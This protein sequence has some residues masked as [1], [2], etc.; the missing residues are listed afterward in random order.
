MPV[1]RTRAI[2]RR[3]RPRPLRL[4]SDE[5]EGGL[6]PSAE[7]SEAGVRLDPRLELRPAHGCR[8]GRLRAQDLGGAPRPRVRAREDAVDLDPQ[9]ARA[10]RGGPEERD[11]FLRQRPLNV[12]LRALGVAR[13]SDRVPNEIDGDRRMKLPETAHTSLP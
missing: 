3:R 13:L 5:G 6:R 1:T 2:S 8:P 10:V 11:A 12:F 9:C 4:V 7:R